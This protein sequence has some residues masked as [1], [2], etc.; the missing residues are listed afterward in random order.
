[1]LP[2]TGIKTS[3]Q[4]FVGFAVSPAFASPSDRVNGTPD[5]VHDTDAYILLVPPPPLPTLFPYTTLFRSVPAPV[6]VP[7]VIA[8]GP[9]NDDV[10]VS[11]A[12]ATNPPPTP[13]FFSTVT[14]NVCGLP[15][16]FVE[17]PDTVI[18]GSTT[19]SVSHGPSAAL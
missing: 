16:A 17:L 14:V 1:M 15:T 2:D 8:P 12:A 10:T 6:H 5:T 18:R 19:V 9:V 13:R 3:T 11:P 7:P 4:V